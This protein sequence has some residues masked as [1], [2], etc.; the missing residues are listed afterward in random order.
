M[1]KLVA[2]ALVIGACWLIWTKI[3]EPP[4]EP[5]P[6][7]KAAMDHFAKQAKDDFNSPKAEEA[8]SACRR[9]AGVG[10]PAKTFQD[11]TGAGY[12]AETAAKF[13]DCVVNYMYPVDA[14]KTEEYDKKAGTR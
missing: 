4:Y 9:I 8:R 14:K 2:V 1:G 7:F 3:A 13:I 5:P 12:S 6:G 11:V 10:V